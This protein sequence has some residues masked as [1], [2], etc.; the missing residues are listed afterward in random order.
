MAKFEERNNDDKEE[1]LEFGTEDS[2]NIRMLGVWLG[3][4]EDFKQRLK[5][6]GAAWAKIRVQLRGSKL[7]KKTQAKIVECCVEST[8]L[9][10]CAVRTWQVG[11]INK[12]QSCMDK[13]Y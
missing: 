1:I 13:K 3:E 9:F 6:A 10:D 12:L 4:G 8:L 2:N 11:E 5:K 7:P